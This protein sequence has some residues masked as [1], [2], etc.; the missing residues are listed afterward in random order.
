L[1]FNRHP[2]TFFQPFFGKG[3]CAGAFLKSIVARPSAE[4]RLGVNT[5][6]HEHS[7]LDG[8]DWD[9]MLGRPLRYLAYLLEKLK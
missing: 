9:K 3:I 6:V 8:I 4:H 7:W 5:S 1:I 2:P